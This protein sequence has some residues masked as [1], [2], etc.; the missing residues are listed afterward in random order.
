MNGTESFIPTGWQVYDDGLGLVYSPEIVIGV[1]AL[2]PEFVD[3]FSALPPNERG[4][5]RPAIVHGEIDS[6]VSASSIDVFSLSDADLAAPGTQIVRNC[7]QANNLAPVYA[8]ANAIVRAARAI[9]A[10][11]CAT[12]LAAGGARIGHG[13]LRRPGKRCLGG[14][15]SSPRGSANGFTTTE[16]VVVIALITALS[17]AA[18]VFFTG[19]HDL[20]RRHIVLGQFAEAIQS[21]RHLPAGDDLTWQATAQ[22]LLADVMELDP[23]TTVYA[24]GSRARWIPDGV[25]VGRTRIAEVALLTDHT[26]NQV[27]LAGCNVGDVQVTLAPSQLPAQH[28][29]Q[30]VELMWLRSN[31]E[32]THPDLIS[33][34]QRYALFSCLPGP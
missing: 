2:L 19:R 24:D 11:Q 4:I 20:A 9:G 13:A 18:F 16:V 26:N 6:A 34:V 31:L 14:H 32:A 7:L 28:V 12:G 3:G 27:T 21:L 10:C 30:D 8:S 29:L 23:P 25:H 1:F 22:S 5:C 15:P 17:T 33:S